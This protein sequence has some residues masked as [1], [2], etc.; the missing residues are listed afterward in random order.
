MKPGIVPLRPLGVGE[1]LDGAITC[2]RSRFKIMF[3][4]AAVTVT[5]G[6]IISVLLQL[7]VGSLQDIRDLQGSLSPTSSPADGPGDLL[8][9]GDLAGYVVA[10]VMSALLAGLTAAVVGDAVLGRN[11]TLGSALG[12]VLPVFWALLGASILAGLLPTI[13]LLAFI[14]G[15]VFLWAAF[16]LATPAVVLERTGP[17][18]AL[19]RSW[20][21]VLPAW[22]RVFGIR[23]LGWLIGVIVGSVLAVPFAGVGM[24]FLAGGGSSAGELWLI[25]L[26]ITLGGI[27]GGIV[28]QPFVAAVDTLLYVDQRMRREGLDLELARAAGVSPAPSAPSPD[29]EGATGWGTARQ[30]D[31]PNR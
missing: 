21:L 1:I 24:I 20:R 19:G 22:W 28:S 31:P 10:A 4:M 3:G 13:G 27:L 15:G 6:Q 23:L 30:P 12:R 11:T 18:K 7:T 5:I 25:L 8:Y 26:L 2:L 29:Q 9:P 16:G 17:I 14:I